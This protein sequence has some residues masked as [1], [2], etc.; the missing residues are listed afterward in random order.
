MGRRSSIVELPDEV[1]RVIDALVRD[2]RATLDEIL[3]H[4]RK[5][6][7]PKPSRS[8]LGRYAKGARA[9]MA[10]YREAQE[11]ARVWI[12]KL[13]AEPEGDVG[14]LL[15]EMLRALA[16]QV[17]ASIG[18]DKAGAAP[19]DV[20]LLAKALKDVGAA[21]KA[22]VDIELKLREV[23]SRAKAA[24]AE[25]TRAAIKAGLSEEAVEAIRSKILGIAA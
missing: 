7:L 23:R 2:G 10:R 13:E 21:S 19:M 15:P 17:M 3:A 14:R 24:A 8:A 16:F 22:N 5:L 1:R 11:V 18:D 12:D 20:M 4:L 9:Q 25:V 6:D